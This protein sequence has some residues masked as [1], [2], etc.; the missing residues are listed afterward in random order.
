MVKVKDGNIPVG[1]ISFIKRSYLENFDIGFA[2]LPEFNR[3][4][5]AYE[6]AKAILE[7]VS[8]HP[9]YYPVLATTVP[10]NE[11]S[12]RLLIKLGLHFE[13][14][15]EVEEERLFVYSNGDATVLASEGM[16]T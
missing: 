2:F 13:K 8:R 5:Y 11:K 4:G 14:E 16:K 1:I 3:Y 9:E 6:A 7:M 12:I 15:I 10:Q